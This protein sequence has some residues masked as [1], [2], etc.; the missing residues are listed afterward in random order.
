MSKILRILALAAGSWPGPQDDCPSQDHSSPGTERV[1]GA[2]GL[3]G[4]ASAV[5]VVTTPLRSLLGRQRY[6][7]HCEY[8]ASLVYTTT[9]VE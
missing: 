2:W 1:C 8:E 5:T 4:G 6:E 3:G 7:D 9:G